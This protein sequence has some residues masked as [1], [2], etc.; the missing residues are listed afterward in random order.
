M[1]PLSRFQVISIYRL[2][3]RRTRRKEEDSSPS[4]SVV[5]THNSFLDLTR[6]ETIYPIL[7]F[8][9]STTPRLSLAR[10]PKFTIISIHIRLVIIILNEINHSFTQVNRD[11]APYYAEAGFEDGV[12]HCD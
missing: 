1:V 12:V 4:I 5:S 7:S 11:P 10:R 6:L 2:S 9:Q 8:V 3:S